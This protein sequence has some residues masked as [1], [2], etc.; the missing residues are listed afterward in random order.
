[1][2][3]EPPAADAATPGAA[4]P[5]PITAAHRSPATLEDIPGDVLSYLCESLSHLDYVRVHNPIDPF[6]YAVLCRRGSTPR[7]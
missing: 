4:A 1:M 2:S 7:L 5:A 6:V 3:P